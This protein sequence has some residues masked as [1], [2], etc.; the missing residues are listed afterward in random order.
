MLP[1]EK[2]IDLEPL[3]ASI[4]IFVLFEQ[5]RGKGESYYKNE[6]ICTIPQHTCKS[7]NVCF[8]FSFNAPN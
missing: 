3:K 2:Q 5:P 6:A 1:G 7:L 4:Y 8:A